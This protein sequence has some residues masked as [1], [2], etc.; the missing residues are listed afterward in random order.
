[1]QTLGLNKESS[2]RFFVYIFGV[3][4]N[5]LKTIDI[6]S[7]CI[8]IVIKAYLF[9]VSIDLPNAEAEKNQK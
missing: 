9:P 7:Q 5:S 1:M 4:T 2:N 6:E 8:A 3:K